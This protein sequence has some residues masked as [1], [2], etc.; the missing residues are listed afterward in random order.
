MKTCFS[1][2]TYTYIFESST[3]ILAC[4]R[5]NYSISFFVEVILFQKQIVLLPW[6]YLWNCTHRL[7]FCYVHVCSV[8]YTCICFNVCAYVL[9][10]CISLLRFYLLLCVNACITYVYL[11]LYLYVVLF[12]YYQNRDCNYLKNF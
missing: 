7:L 1:G 8:F 9:C 12:N 10:M 5:L 3:H 4:T 11:F 6:K 2:T